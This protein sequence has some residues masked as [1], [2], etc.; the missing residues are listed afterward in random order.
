MIGS[1]SNPMEHDVEMA[2]DDVARSLHTIAKGA[3]GLSKEPSE[4]L[5]TAA[6][7]VTRAAES[8]RRHA[9]ATTRNGPGIAVLVGGMW[10]MNLSY[11]GFNQYI[12]Q[13][14]L[15]AKKTP[16]AVSAAPAASS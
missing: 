8:V 7:N 13:R 2:L 6:A 11:W 15:A 4:A 5:A 9:A 16:V 3:A 12:I 14:A 1:L 10:I